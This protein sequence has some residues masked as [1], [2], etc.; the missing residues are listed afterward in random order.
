MGV[1]DQNGSAVAVLNELSAPPASVQGMAQRT[2]SQKMGVKEGSRA[3]L[4]NVPASALDALR[5][6]ELELPGALSGK[7]DYLHLFVTTQQRLRS[8]FGELRDHL[9]SR[10]MLWVSWPKGGRLG[11]DLDMKKVIAI[12]YG[13]GMV[14]ST[15]LR[16]DEVWA[17]L[18]F[19]HPK[20][21]NIYRNSFGTLLGQGSEEHEEAESPEQGQ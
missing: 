5:L 13:L 20:P 18:K 17:G 15:C 11:T 21:G 1:P 10:G 7:F 14:E 4:V 9:D 8:G 6:P 19:T 12:G 2:V 16:V 3:H